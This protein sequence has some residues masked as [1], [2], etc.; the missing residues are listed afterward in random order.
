[1]VIKNKVN[2]VKNYAFKTNICE[3]LA[4]S[5]ACACHVVSVNAFHAAGEGRRQVKDVTTFVK[6]CRNCGIS[7]PYLK[8]E[9]KMH[10]D[11]Y[12][13]AWY[14]FI[15]SWNS[16]W[17]FRKVRKQTD[18][19]SVKPSPRSKV[20]NITFGFCVL[21]IDKLLDPLELKINANYRIISQFSQLF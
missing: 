20:L 4:L 9:W 17:N 12:K 6:K 14:W 1:M 15:N 21:Y 5:S 13:H 2:K 19:C 7:W 10:S 3:H 16:H 18:F 11:K 8:P